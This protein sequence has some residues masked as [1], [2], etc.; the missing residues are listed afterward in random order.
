MQWKCIACLFLP[1]ELYEQ[2][3]AEPQCKLR[4]FY[5]KCDKI[6]MEMD[7]KNGKGGVDNSDRID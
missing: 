6:V 1:N 4:W 5:D 3:I 2:L 7:I